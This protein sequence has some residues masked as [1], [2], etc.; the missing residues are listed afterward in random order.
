MVSD[1]RC[2]FCHNTQNLHIHHIFG[3][4]ANR[5]KSE[6][7]GLTVYLCAYHHN[8]GKKCVHNN[9]EMDLILK[10]QAQEYFE[11]ECGLHEDFMREFGKN[12]L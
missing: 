2:Y 1:E 8:L 6:K 7:Y 11:E 10:K 4:T 5:R 9:K 12:Y 3:G